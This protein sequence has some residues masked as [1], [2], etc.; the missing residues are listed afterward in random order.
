MRGAVGLGLTSTAKAS[1]VS[2]RREGGRAVWSTR[3]NYGESSPVDP[4]LTASAARRLRNWR[5]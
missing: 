2:S 1:K 3:V 5:K 4:A